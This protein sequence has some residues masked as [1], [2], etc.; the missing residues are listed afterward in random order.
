M[1]PGLKEREAHVRAMFDMRAGTFSKTV[2]RDY[3][4]VIAAIPIMAL[5]ALCGMAALVT[6]FATAFRR[7]PSG[8]AS[9]MFVP[10]GKERVSCAPAN[11]IHVLR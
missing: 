2:H 4:A 10:A 5:L 9:A 1:V 3:S 11:P 6:L 7:A 8:A